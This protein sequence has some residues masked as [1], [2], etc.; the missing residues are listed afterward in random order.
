M[1]RQKVRAKEDKRGSGRVVFDQ[2]AAL[3]AL[4]FARGGEQLRLPVIQ[5]APDDAEPGRVGR[6]P[7]ARSVAPELWR[8]WLLA[9]HGSVVEGLIATGTAPVASIAAELV[10]AYQVV[11]RTAHG[12]SAPEI[13]AMEILE[14]VKAAA[15]LRQAAQRY[16]APY[17]H[18]PAP[19]QLKV[20]APPQRAAIGLFVGSVDQA[21]RVLPASEQQASGL[22]ARLLSG[23]Q[24]NQQVSEAVELDLNAA[25][26]NAARAEAPES[27]GK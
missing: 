2:A 27:E 26:L 12:R 21:G 1:A 24:G 6:P 18:S 15:S 13:P 23:T 9:K 3:E 19:T 22:L 8:Q 25:D 4:V 14:L 16:G 17:Q 10:Q 20:E 5:A 7:G 11:Y